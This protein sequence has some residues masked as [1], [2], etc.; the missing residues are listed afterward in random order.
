MSARAFRVQELRE[1][2]GT[3]VRNCIRKV[4]GRSQL[5]VIL[6]RI[7]FITLFSNESISKINSNN[8]LNASSGMGTEK[9]QLKI[10]YPLEPRQLLLKSVL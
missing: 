3:Q 2:T 4:A 9:G 1:P 10:T 7:P 8:P 5:M 6:S